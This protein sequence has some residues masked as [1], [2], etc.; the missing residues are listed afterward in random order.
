MSDKIKCPESLI[1]TDV[2]EPLIRDMLERK[3]LEWWD[4]AEVI[5]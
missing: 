5:E 3:W 1:V 2:Q 4:Q